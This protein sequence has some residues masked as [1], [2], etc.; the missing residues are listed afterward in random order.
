MKIITAAFFILCICPF[1][2]GQSLIESNDG[3]YLMQ[4][5]DGTID[6]I[7]LAYLN[8]GTSVALKENGTYLILDRDIEIVSSDHD[9]DSKDQ[10]SNKAFD[11]LGN[12]IFGR[13]VI[14]VDRVKLVGLMNSIE[15]G[16]TRK[17]WVKT[18]IN[19]AGKVTYVELDENNTNVV[20]PDALKVALSLVSKYLFEPD[21][22]APSEQCGLVKLNINR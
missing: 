4:Y 1:V 10:D 2:N 19:R 21:S 9:L 8:D 11:D 22:Y 6:T 17:I 13:K 14:F 5:E 15:S 18:C 12:G 16:E 3:T 20:D 7:Q